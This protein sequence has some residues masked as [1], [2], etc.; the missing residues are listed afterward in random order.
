MN[1]P[2][3]WLESRG[4]KIAC[5]IAD[6]QPSP[7]QSVTV[8]TTASAPTIVFCSGFKSNMQGTKALA[9]QRLCGTNHWPCVRFDY[10]GHG[11]S[12]G[13]FTAGNIDS[14]LHD[15]LTVIDAINNP[16]GVVLVGSSMGAWIA[17]VSYTHLT[18]PTI[19]S[20]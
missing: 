10:S 3:T 18:L 1:T 7:A 15:A 4:H 9:L 16:Q 20:V 12:G 14:W 11:Q 8:P 5:C 2:V 19:C 17:T 6:V 13:E